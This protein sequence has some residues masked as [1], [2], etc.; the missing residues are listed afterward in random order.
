[1]A[2]T[3]LVHRKPLSLWLDESPS[4]PPETLPATRTQVAKEFQWRSAD[5]RFTPPRLMRTSHLY[6]VVSMIWNH[7]MPADAATHWYI[8][9]QFGAFYSQEYMETAVRCCLRELVRRP[10]LTLEMRKRLEF[11]S[12]YLKRRRPDMYAD[13]MKPQAQIES[14]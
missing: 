7:S 14:K 10:D 1:M 11:M 4:S 12:S 6:N 9:H 3:D 13:L 8:R 5:N 2:E